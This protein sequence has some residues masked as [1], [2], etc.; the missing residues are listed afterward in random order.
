MAHHS[1][2]YK[3]KITCIQRNTNKF[4]VHIGL[5]NIFH[6]P[7][8]TRGSSHVGVSNIIM[9]LSPRI[10][11]NEFQNMLSP[12]NTSVTIT[13]LIMSRVKMQ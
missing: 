1:I 6:A 13:I 2:F 7:F 12:D 4:R 3:T 9:K 8:G 11:T 5:Y 10:N